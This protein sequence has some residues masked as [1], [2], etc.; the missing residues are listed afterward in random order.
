[1]GCIGIP[2]YGQSGPNYPPDTLRLP[3][4]SFHDLTVFKDFGLGGSR[5]M[6][7]RAG[8]FN[9]FNAAYPDTIAF[10]DIDTQVNTSC[11]TRVSGVPNGAGGT[12][13]VCDPT[14]AFSL[15]DNTLS[16]FGKIINKRGHRVIELAVRFF[17]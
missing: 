7:I 16:N 13:D 1:M 17:F 12:A 8:F 11:A 10:S 4:R 2:A 9:I 14:G 5:R 15:T 6:Q 3:G